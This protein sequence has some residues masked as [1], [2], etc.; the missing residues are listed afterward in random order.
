[1][2]PNTVRAWSDAGDFA[3]TGSTRE[4]I[5]ATAWVTSSASLR[6]PRPGATEG[7]AGASSVERS[8]PRPATTGQRPR[9]G[10]QPVADRSTGASRRRPRRARPARSAGGLRG[11]DLDE[12][13]A[14]AAISIRDAGDRRLVAIWSVRAG[15]LSPASDAHSPRLGPARLVDVPTTYGSSGRPGIAGGVATDERPGHDAGSARRVGRVAAVIPGREAVGRLLVVR[16]APATDD[17]RP[18][19]ARHPGRAIGAM[20]AVADRRGEVAPAAPPSRGA[21]PGRERHRQRARPRPDPVRAGRPRHGPVRGR[22]G[23]R[24]PPPADGPGGGR[25]QPRAVVERTCS[26]VATSRRVAVAWPRSPPRRPLL[27]HEATAT[28]PAARDVRAAVVQEGFDTICTAPLIDGDQ[29]LGDAQRLPRPAADVDRRRARD[30]RP[31]W[32]R[33][34]RSPSGPRRTSSRWRHGPR[35]CSRSSSSARG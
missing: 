17:A 11:D 26:A 5:D 21:A 31:P 18:G 2:H 34:R 9:L 30:D 25:G 24:V 14:T 7:A 15:R 27:R 20:V 29:V 10:S 13:L 32:R 35:S 3:I 23:C 19:A 12:D 16:S 4:A 28:T 1:M 33:R 6:R 8:R 22:P